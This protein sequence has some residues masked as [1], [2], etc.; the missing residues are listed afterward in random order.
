MI[1]KTTKLQ[2]RR[3]AEGLTNYA[4]R[5]ALLKSGKTRVTFRRSNKR[6]IMQLINFE[7]AGDKTLASAYSDKLSQF[8]W[9]DKCNIPTAYLTGYWLGK[10]ALA[11]GINEAVFDM[12]MISPVRGGKVFAG[13]NGLV[14]SGLKVPAGS[15]AFPKP[16]RLCKAE[17]KE[18][19][20]Q[21]KQKIDSLKKE[22]NEKVNADAV[23]K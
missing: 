12:G 2:F 7:P 3:R 21:A 4:K 16:E 19:F 6:I 22:S 8:G 17:S 23:E 5:L 9:A 18:K 15:E 1:K 11:V 14:D 13:L 10:Q 20:D